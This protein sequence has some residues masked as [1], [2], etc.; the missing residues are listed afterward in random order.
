MIVQKI[1]NIECAKLYEF[2]FFI[3]RLYTKNKEHTK[4]LNSS[5]I[6]VFICEH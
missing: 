4:N 3:Y 2:D 5:S 6:K 1:F